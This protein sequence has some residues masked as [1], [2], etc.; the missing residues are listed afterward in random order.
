MAIDAVLLEGAKRRI[1]TMWPHLNELQRRTL[2]GVEARDEQA[3][4]GVY[5]YSIALVLQPALLTGPQIN[6]N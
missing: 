6:V 2:L 3:N 1:T 5:R 4:V